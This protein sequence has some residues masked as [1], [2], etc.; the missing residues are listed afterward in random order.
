MA[1]PLDNSVPV[2]S[3]GASGNYWIDS[4]IRGVKWGAGVGTPVTLTY[5]FPDASNITSWYWSTDDYGSVYGSGEPWNDY[6][7]GLTATEQAAAVS[8]MTQWSAVANVGFV[9][10]PDTMYM[11]GEIRVA[12]T[13]DPSVDAGQ[14][15]AYYPGSTP[16]AG[17]IWLNL[18]AFWDGNS[19]GNYGYLA[20][21]HE[22]GHAL[23]L[24][25]TFVG[26]GSLGGALPLNE[27]GYKYSIMSY[28]ALAGAPNSWADFNPTTPM[29]YDIAAVQYLYGA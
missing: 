10:V 6:A 20:A 24:S 12:W 17:D 7:T 5:S 22:L 3:V 9:K 21:L 26:S 19:P 27:D 28:S 25:H 4:L 16:A 2:S 8:A 14:A 18:A 29:L 11:V 23:G 1:T 15:W 13:Y